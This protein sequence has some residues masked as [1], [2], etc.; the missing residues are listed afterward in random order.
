MK[1]KTLLWYEK[2]QWLCEPLNVQHILLDE[3][4]M[5]VIR[6]YIKHSKH[7][8]PRD[9]Y[10]DAQAIYVLLLWAKFVADYSCDIS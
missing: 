5:H 7:F 2:Q 8:H 3:G 10:F 9:E 4:V 6:E 1:L